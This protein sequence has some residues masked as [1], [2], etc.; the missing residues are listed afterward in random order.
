MDVNEATQETRFAF[1][2]N[3]ANFL[4]KVDEPRIAAATLSLMDM[5]SVDRLDNQRFLDIGCGSG[6]ASLVAHRLGAIVHSFDF[7]K[8]SVACSH[9]IKRKFGSES[10]SWRV[11]QG[12]VLDDEYLQSLGLFDIVYSWG[13][14]HH[15]GQMDQAIEN[16][17]HR[18]ASGGLLYITIYNDQGA[19]S[20]RWGWIKQ[21]YHRLPVS[22]RFFWVLLVS[23]VYEMKFACS[24]LMR[25]KNPLP[26][27]DWKAK[28]QDRG[29]TAWYDWVDWVGGWPFEVSTPEKIVHSLTT[30][31]FQLVRLKTVGKGWGCNEYVFRRHP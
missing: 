22:L 25:G 7:D 16:V 9:E 19:A 20:R 26:F 18:V 21:T 5:L 13:V 30:K 1:G 8:A 29:M 14:L 23:S 31:G 10:P 4:K 27:G 3:W 6:L 28:A 12:S 15:T 2:K 11:E 24:R 17:T